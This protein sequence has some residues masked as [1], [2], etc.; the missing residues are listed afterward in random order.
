MTPRPIS[1]EAE[2]AK[3]RAARAGLV[4]AAR[5]LLARHRLGALVNDVDGL[6]AAAGSDALPPGLVE[7]ARAA[8]VVLEGLDRGPTDRAWRARAWGAGS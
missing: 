3:V 2:R 1:P 4:D 6:A 5:A 7:L 8:A